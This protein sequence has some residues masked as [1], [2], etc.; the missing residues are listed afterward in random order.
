M[1]PFIIHEDEVEYRF[2][3]VSGPKYLLRGPR[4]DFGMVVLMPGEDF[5]T[6]YHRQVEENFFTLEGE[7][8]I[9]I[10][11]EPFTLRPGDLC[12]VPPMH[13]HY[14][15]NNGRTPWKAIFVKA[16]YD[17]KDKVDVDWLPGQ[18]FPEIS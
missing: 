14:L 13:P 8:E 15:I 11:G 4:S 18:P 1:K 7:V 17:P 3:G 5:Q 2:D 6:H 9:Y 10:N 16:P 12:H